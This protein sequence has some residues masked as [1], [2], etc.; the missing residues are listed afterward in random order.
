MFHHDYLA[1]IHLDAVT[2]RYGDKTVVD[3]V[4]FEVAA[5]EVLG[6]L[7]PNGAGKTTTIRM[8][9]GYLMPTRGHV[10]VAGF[11]MAEAGLEAARRIGYLPERPPLY[12]T[13][14]VDGYL[15]FVAKVKGIRG[16]RLRQE[17]ERVNAACHLEGV[18]RSEIFKLSKGYRQRVGLAQALL[19]PPDILLLDEPGNGLDPAQIQETREVIRGFAESGSV[20]LS[21]HILGEVTQICGRI[22]IIDSG[23]LLAID[24]AEGLERAAALTQIVELEA[25]APGPALREL[26]GAVDGILDVELDGGP[27]RHIARCRVADSELVAAAIARAVATR[28]ELHRLAAVRPGLESIFLHYVRPAAM[29]TAA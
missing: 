13:L 7:G 15:R 21:T 12:D 1:M 14:T 9:A 11:D 10:R 25:T 26:L 28:F 2:K 19:G 29:S 8:I 18:F 3:A 23:R 16:G 22:A 27:S 17:L 5:G 20:L 6:F 4:S 24:T